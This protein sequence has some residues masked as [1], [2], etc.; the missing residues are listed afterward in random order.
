GSPPT[1]TVDHGLTRD[2]LMQLRRRWRPPEPPTA[3]ILL[4]HG[5]TEHS[6]RYEHVGRWLADAGFDVVAIDARGA[7]ESGG[8]RSYV[9]RFADF[10]DDVEDQLVEVR[11]LGVP[12]VLLGHSMGGLIALDL[13]TSDRPQPDLVVVSGPALGAQVPLRLRLLAPLAGR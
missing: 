12:V 9:D 3:A 8:R 13:A 6:G 7:G 10:V 5:I 4:V 1:S 11:R 2:G